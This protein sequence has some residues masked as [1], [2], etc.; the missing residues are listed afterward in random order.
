MHTQAYTTQS[1]LDETCDNMYD[2][3]SKQLVTYDE[4][5]YR[6]EGG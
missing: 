4:E 6:Q 2:E 1:Q 5:L 3:D